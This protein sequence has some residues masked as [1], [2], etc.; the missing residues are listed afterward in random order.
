[1]GLVIVLTI[2]AFIGLIKGI[3]KKSRTMVIGAVIALILIGVTLLYFYN[4][5]Y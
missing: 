5:P 4:N 3:V 2:A 1:M